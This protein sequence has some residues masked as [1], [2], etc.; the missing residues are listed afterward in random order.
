M[1]TWKQN[2]PWS[3]FSL[4]IFEILGTEI[5]TPSNSGKG[6]RGWNLKKIATKSVSN[7]QTKLV[8]YFNYVGFLLICVMNKFSAVALRFKSESLLNI[9]RRTRCL[10]TASTYGGPLCAR[11]H[12]AQWEELAEL[13]RWFGHEKSV[14]A[15]KTVSNSQLSIWFMNIISWNRNEIY[16]LRVRY[17]KFIRTYTY[18]PKRLAY[19]APLSEYCSLTCYIN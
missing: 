17:I 10:P 3:T 2:K 5:H 4:K 8:Y 13:L 15:W 19:F 7:K 12:E 16:L 14:A 18:S 11:R 1:T 6:L 9:W